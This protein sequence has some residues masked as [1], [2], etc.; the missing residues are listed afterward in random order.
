MTDRE[1]MNEAIK[2]AEAALLLIDHGIKTHTQVTREM[3]G[4]DWEEN[5]ELLARENELLSAAGGNRVTMVEREQDEEGDGG[6]A[7]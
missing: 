1:C 6:D 7:D 4:G 5:M 2:E 3:G